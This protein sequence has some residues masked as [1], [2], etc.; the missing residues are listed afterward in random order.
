MSV[1][2][3]SIYSWH[4]RLFLH[5]QY[6]PDTDV[7]SYTVNIF[8]TLTSVPI[9]VNIFLTLTSVPT[10]SI[11]SWHWYLFLQQSKYSWQWHLFPKQSIYSWHWPQCFSTRN[12]HMLN[13]SRLYRVCSLQYIWPIPP[14]PFVFKVICVIIKCALCG[15]CNVHLVNT[16]RNWKIWVK[17]WTKKKKDT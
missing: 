11:Y 10:Q 2:T 16:F 7:C 1:P 14:A 4:W 15:Y 12:H 5:S 3:Q 9:A 17:T 8:L 13:V 6:I